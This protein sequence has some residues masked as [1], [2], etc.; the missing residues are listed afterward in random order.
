MSEVGLEMYRIAERI[1]PICRSI[2]GQGVRETLNI[3]SEYA[4]GMTVHEVPTGTKV[5]DWTVPKEWMIRDAYIEDESGNHVIDFKKNNLHV[6]G[7][8]ISVDQWVPL[9]ELLEY[10]YVQADQPNV[11]PYVT[12]YY[13]ERFGFCMSQKQR[14]ALKPGKYHMVIDSELIV[15]LKGKNNSH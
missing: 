1:F 5:F 12:S 2:T 9:E 7:Y 3:L 10:V 8:S 13:K 6:M 4:D 15:V 11:V 14:D